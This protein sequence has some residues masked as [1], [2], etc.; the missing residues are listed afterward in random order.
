MSWYKHTDAIL[1]GDTEIL[2]NIVCTVFEAHL[3]HQ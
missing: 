3:D 1:A 2:L